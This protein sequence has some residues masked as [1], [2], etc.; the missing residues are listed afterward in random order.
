MRFTVTLALIAVA[1]GSSAACGATAAPDSVSAPAVASGDGREVALHGSLASTVAALGREARG[2]VWVSWEVPANSD[3]GFAC[4]LDSKWRRTTCHLEKA[5]QS[6][7]SNDQDHSALSGVLLVYARWEA[8]K[9]ERVR[10]FSQECAVDSGSVPLVRVTGVTPSASVDFLVGLLGDAQRRRDVD[11]PLVAVSYHADAAADRALEKLAEPGHAEEV[12]EQALFWIGQ[13][14]GEHGAQ[15]LMAFIQREP[16]T[17]MRKKAIFALS[18]NDAPSARP[19]IVEVARNDRDPE[20][21]GEAL[22]WL[23]QSGAPNAG[24]V[25]LAAIDHD[26]S[27]EVRKKGVFALTQLDEDEGVPLLIKLAREKRDLEI[28]KQAIFWLGQSDDPRAMS[29]FEDVLG[30][31]KQ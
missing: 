3:M 17:E 22:F 13:S 29:F 2:P 24:D 21:R 30:G 10:P 15:F 8:G 1:A 26:P 19:A 4:C 11:E 31:K 14:R 18:Q 9:V 16:S 28:R 5:N 6:S 7:G 27:D 12:R 25:I 23:A 20:V